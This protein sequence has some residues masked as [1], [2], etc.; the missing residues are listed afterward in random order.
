MSTPTCEAILLVEATMPCL[1]RTGSREAAAT[2]VSVTDE[3][4]LGAGAVIEVASKSA[5]TSELNTR[6]SLDV[7]M[8]MIIVVV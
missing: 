4:N 8:E 6:R 5:I 7:F 2:L 3:K 1:A